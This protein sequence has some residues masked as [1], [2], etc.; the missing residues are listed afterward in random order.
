[1]ELCF[2]CLNFL[3]SFC[4]HIASKVF[5]RVPRFPK[6]TEEPWQ[7]I[8]VHDVDDRHLLDDEKQQGRALTYC[9]ILQLEV[10]QFLLG[11]LT[12]LHAHFDLISYLLGLSENFNGFLIVKDI[13]L[14]LS[15]YF[16]YLLFN[17]CLQ[18]AV[19]VLSLDE[20][21]LICVQLSVFTKND[22]LQQLFGQST[23]GN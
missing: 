3:C 8:L 1:M 14:R 7:A 17:V 4:K 15:Q 19:L 6:E 21:L 10:I 9:R 20:F 11:R 2:S 22:S 16:E 13:T 18:F 5:K 12:S 23:E